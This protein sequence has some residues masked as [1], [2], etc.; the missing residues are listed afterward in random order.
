[1]NVRREEIV[2]I[3]VTGALSEGQILEYDSSKHYYTALA[4]G[5][6]VAVLLEDV[7]ESQDPAM[8]LVGFAGEYDE[9]EVTL[10]E[11]ANT[12]KDQKAELRAAGIFVLERSDA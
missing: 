5:T 4:K 1:M 3:D 11:D 6:A 12:E 7:D 8:A 9:D 2:P 10:S